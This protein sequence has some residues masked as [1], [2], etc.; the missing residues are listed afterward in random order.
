M[1]IVVDFDA[2]AAHGDCVVEAPEIFDLGDDDDVVRVLVQEPEEELRGKAQA[3]A[4]ACPMV[5]IRIEA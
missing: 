4:D 3:A 5:A 1:R 2:C